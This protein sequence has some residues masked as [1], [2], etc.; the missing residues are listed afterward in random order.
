MTRGH[1]VY[2]YD[3]KTG[4]LKRKI[5][6]SYKG[7]ISRNFLADARGHAFVPRLTENAPADGLDK[8]SSKLTVELVELDDNLNEL[9]ASPLAHYTADGSENTHGITGVVYLSDQS[10]V[11]A[12]SNGYLY[13]LEPKLD[14]ATELQS[15]G[16]F[17]PDGETYAPSL[18]ALDGERYV[19]G[20]T[21]KTGS[22]V[23]DWVV[24]DLNTKSSTR[25]EFPI[26]DNGEQHI[27]NLLLYGSI[28]RDDSGAGYVVGRFID[29]DSKRERPIFLQM[30]FVRK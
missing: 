28:T 12:S 21:A 1:V 14:A 17:H 6:G 19:A 22:S 30:Q 18:F 23:F 13:R 9:A 7:H 10:M 11:F 2:R 8:F 26:Q 3:T 4:D 20:L 24:Y 5:V 29:P 16:W 15:L 25:E 27:R